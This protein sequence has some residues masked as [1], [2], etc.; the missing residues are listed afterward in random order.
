V[1]AATVAAR[2]ADGCTAIRSLE[3]RV[4][5]PV[6]NV[7]L[8]GGD[9]SLVATIGE[10]IAATSG[11]SMDRARDRS[12][13]LVRIK[14]GGV[15]L[16]LCHLAE[17]AEQ[18]EVMRFV[19]QVAGGLYPVPV[20]VLTELSDP[21]IKLSLL[22]VGAMDCLTRPLNL[23]R[24]V[25]LLD[26]LTVRV[27]YA[28]ADGEKFLQCN[29]EAVQDF[30]LKSA[31]MQQLMDQI[32]RV[33]PLDST[34]LLTGATGTG[35]SHLARLIHDLSPRRA[36]PFLTV[37]CAALAPT[38]IESELF[39]H[40]RGAFTG[41]DRDHIG[42]FEEAGTGTLFLD[43]V[44]SLTP[45][46]QA[47]LLQAAEERVVQPIGSNR[48][49]SLRARLVV[50][51]NRDLEREVA[52]GN[53]RGDLFFRLNVISFEVPRLR[54]RREAIVP[55][56]Q[57]FLEEFAGRMG[58]P[59]KG[60]SRAALTVLEGYDWPGNVRQLRNAIERAAALCPGWEIE[61][62][63]LPEHIHRRTEGPNGGIPDAAVLTPRI[64]GLRR[65]Q[66]SARA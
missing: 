9:A 17:A 37:H 59:I 49:V 42:K 30:L 44:D 60:F 18:P 55:L 39:G 64:R 8:V 21:E 65:P 66:G 11:C 45:E 24:V 31:A 12:D 33:A 61:P 6:A 46:V 32:Y 50:A 27:R 29:G 7:L 47:K 25:F 54:D 14:T 1:F 35:K 38:L 34:I 56:A 16:V 52:A 23:S 3:Q 43:E 15:A 20:V 63:D 51:T 2:L 48:T 19:E 28:E 13:A 4:S 62:G 36:R 5:K 53:F 26:L 22:K 57:H 41:A 40:A 58:R 10:Q